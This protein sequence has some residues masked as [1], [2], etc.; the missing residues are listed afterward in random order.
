MRSHVVSTPCEGENCPVCKLGAL[1]RQNHILW[2]D[3]R[4]RRMFVRCSGEKCL[5]CKAEKASVADPTKSVQLEK[6][7]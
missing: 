1:P 6:V 4:Q 3:V 7:L 2:D 5:L